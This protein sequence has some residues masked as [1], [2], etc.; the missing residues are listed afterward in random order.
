PPLSV[1]AAINPG[2]VVIGD[3][4]RDGVPDLV[5]RDVDYAVVVLIGLGNGQFAPGVR[6]DTGLAYARVAIGDLNADGILDVI[7]PTDSSGQ[8]SVFLG[9]GD[10]TLGPQAHYFS[11]NSPSDAVIG[12][13]NEDAVADLAIANGAGDVSIKIGRGDGTFETV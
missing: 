8:F 9:I 6:Y 5:V 13:F 11:G 10:G 12:D 7:A 3:L 1:P 4:N 2:S